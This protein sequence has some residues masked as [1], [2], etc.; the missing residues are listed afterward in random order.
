MELENN[1]YFWQKLDTLVLS[2]TMVIDHK[3]NTSHPNYPNLIYP[4]DYGYLE[5]DLN[6]NDDRISFFQGSEETSTVDSIVVCV[7]ILKRDVSVKLL[8][9]CNKQEELAI[10]EILDQTDYQKA[11]LI[12]RGS[13]VPFWAYSM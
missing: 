5:D 4:V 10:L 8:I 9:G 7:D 13:E 12:R 2:S 3:K 6:D 11:V 1:A